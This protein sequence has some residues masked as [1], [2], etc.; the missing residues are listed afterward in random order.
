MTIG[1][2][3]QSEIFASGQ[4]PCCPVEHNDGTGVCDTCVNCICHVSLTFQPFHL[5]YTP[6]ILDLKTSH[7]FKDL[8]EVYLS[9][10]IPPQNRA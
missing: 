8:P 2:S 3:A 4:C 5:T 7:P 6:F 10:F 9:K 1:H